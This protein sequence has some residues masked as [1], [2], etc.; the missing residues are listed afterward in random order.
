ME[1]I[2][3][4]PVYINTGIYKGR[5]GCYDDNEDGKAIV[6]FGDI[7]LTNTYSLIPFDYLSNVNTKVLF[8][9]RD[10][11]IKILVSQ[12]EKNEKLTK[13]KRISYLE[14]IEY[15]NSI[16][17]DRMI[18]SMLHHN[19]SQT[20]IFLSHSSLDK[21]FVTSLAID[22]KNYGF[23]VWLDTWEIL[24]GE[25]IP[26]KIGEGIENCQ[27]VILVLSPESVES[28]WVEQEW[29]TKYLEEIESNKIKLIPIKIKECKIPILLKTKK[30]IDFT[31][32]YSNGLQNICENINKLKDK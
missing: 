25:S 21:K 28:K 8:E 6:L 17:T 31:K 5:I 13:K 11:I 7:F 29:Q 24:A 18:D 15:I 16:L 9:R 22:L 23:D 10:S 12:K 27:F 30:Y 4:G 19:E 14:E 20:K 3:Y 1:I 32:D 2:D 26:K